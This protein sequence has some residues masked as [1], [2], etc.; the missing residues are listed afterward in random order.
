MPFSVRVEWSNTRDVREGMERYRKDVK[1]A[2][3][4]VAEYWKPVIETYAREHAQWTDRTGNARRGLHSFVEELSEDT[5]AL[6]LAHGMDYGLHLELKYAGKY[7]II[8]PALE[9]HYGEIGRMLKGI[10]GS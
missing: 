6:Y 4:Q 8:L 10:F 2:I 9:A 3:R 1:R 7:A 5:V